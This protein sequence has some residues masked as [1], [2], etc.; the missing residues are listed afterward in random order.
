MKQQ[1]L[2]SAEGG[3]TVSRNGEKASA[4]LLLAIL[5]LSHSLLSSFKRNTCSVGSS[6]YEIQFSSPQTVFLLKP[7]LSRLA[8]G[9]AQASLAPL[10]CASTYC[11]SR[12]DAM[13][14]ALGREDERQR[15]TV[16]KIQRDTVWTRQRRIGAVSSRTTEGL[17]LPKRQL[18]LL[19][20]LTRMCLT[21][22]WVSALAR[23]GALNQL[24]TGQRTVLFLQHTYYFS[25]L[26]LHY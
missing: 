14:R 17:N 24:H 20:N 7:L 23:P 22:A 25:S 18:S 3:K 12:E 26:Q 15:E 19:C 1:A 6:K 5:S 10:T 11:T 13:E 21:W 9:P 4:Y 2:D 16:R 8:D